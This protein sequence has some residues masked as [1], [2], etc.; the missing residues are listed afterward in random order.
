MIISAS[1]RTDIPAFY[2]EW[3]LRR[4]KDGFVLVRNPM[5]PNSIGKISLSPDVVD[6]IVFWTKNPKPMLA[7][8]DK[9]RDYPYYFQFT[10]TPYDSDVE[11]HLP[12]KKE[13]IDTFKELS[14]RIGANRVIW[15]CDPILVNRKYTL[16]YHIGR[17]VEMAAELKGYTTK[18]VISFVDYYKSIAGNIKDL[19]LL[20]ITED[21]MRHIARSFS[22]VASENGLRVDTCAEAIDLSEYGIGHSKCVD[23]AIFT[24]ITGFGY[25]VSK[26]KNQRAAC[27]CVESID[28]GAYNTCLHGCKYC[29]ANSSAR[30]VKSN[31]ARYD[32]DSPLLCGEIGGGDIIKDREV[33]S[34][35]SG[36]LGFDI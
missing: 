7:G 18:C 33:R 15:R 5:N 2:S 27:G 16:D 13:V 25:D 11:A 14:D 32:A 34:V 1:R 3:F 4:I 10:L 23:D 36:Q 29:Y 21:D 17:F 12:P 24:E 31:Y 22:A 28:I 8:L 9:L 20:E 26:D 6:G 19:G 30:L 35:Q